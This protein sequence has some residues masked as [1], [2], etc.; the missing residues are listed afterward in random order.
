MTLS[1]ALCYS[2][3]HDGYT[4]STYGYNGD[5]AWAHT[6]TC[7]FVFFIEGWMFERLSWLSDG[8]WCYISANIWLCSCISDCLSLRKWTSVVYQHEKVSEVDHSAGTAILRLNNNSATRTHSGGAATN[9]TTIYVYMTTIKQVKR[10]TFV[11]SYLF[12]R[13]WS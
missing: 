2:G 7:I 9:S 6:S 8:L 5:M 11:L 1:Y 4:H 3:H 10:L 13:L 12:S